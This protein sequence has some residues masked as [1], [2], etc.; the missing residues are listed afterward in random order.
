MHQWKLFSGMCAPLNRLV[1]LLFPHS[2][3]NKYTCNQN[4][5]VSVMIHITLNRGGKYFVGPFLIVK[6]NEAKTTSANVSY[7]SSTWT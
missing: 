1:F 7:Q 2:T 3:K 6:A 4:S 5:S